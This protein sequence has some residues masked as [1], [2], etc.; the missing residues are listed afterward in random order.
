MTSLYYHGTIEELGS[1][2]SNQDG[3]ARFTE[4]E[5]LADENALPIEF[6]TCFYYVNEETGQIRIMRVGRE[7]YAGHKVF[8]I[9]LTLLT[10]V[11]VDSFKQDISNST[12]NA[13]ENKYEGSETGIRYAFIVSF[14]KTTPDDVKT[15]V[16]CNILRLS[17]EEDFTHLQDQIHSKNE[18]LTFMP[19]GLAVNLNSIVETVHPTRVFDYIQN[20]LKQTNEYDEQSLH[21]VRVIA[22]AEYREFMAP[23]VR[24]YSDLYEFRKEQIEKIF[25]AEQD[26]PVQDEQ[27]IVH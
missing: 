22:E 6:A 8:P 9:D 5:N 16:F 4:G 2:F 25:Q 14:T 10:D 1:F 26:Q 15:Q 11:S 20:E 13:F 24:S 27:Q 19:N 12:F 18:E 21:V 3:I 7:T 23:V 17:T